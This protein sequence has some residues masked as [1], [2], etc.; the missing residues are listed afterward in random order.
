MGK[1]PVAL[2]RTAGR[3]EHVIEVEAPARQASEM[4]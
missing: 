1:K 2:T 3:F 4:A